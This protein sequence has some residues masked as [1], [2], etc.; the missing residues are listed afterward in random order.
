MI[1][2]KAHRRVAY[3]DKQELEEEILR[4]HHSGMIYGAYDDGDNAAVIGGMQQA[5]SNQPHE[6]R[7]V[8]DGRW[9]SL[10]QRG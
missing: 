6:K 9:P 2:E 4:R 10:Q 7:T 3:A 5:Q 8:S 1:E